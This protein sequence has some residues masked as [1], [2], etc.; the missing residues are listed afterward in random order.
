MGVIPNLQVT[1]PYGRT[2]PNFSLRGISVANEFSASTASPVGV[3][4]DEVYQA[5]RASHGQQLYDLDR[6]EVLRGPQG[7]LYGRNT[8]GGAV[9]FFTR[10]PQLSGS[11]G[12][13]SV[14]YGEYSTKTLTGAFEFTPV[15]GVFGVRFAGTWAD[16]DG[17]QYNPVQER[18]TGTTDVQAARLTLLW[19]PKNNVD[20]TLKLYT[21][22]DNPVAALP[23][24]QGQLQDRQDALGYSRFDPQAFLGGRHLNDDEVASDTGGNYFSSS[25]GMSLTINWDVNDNW[26]LRSITGYDEG[27]YKNSP[28][29]CD[30]S[31]LDL[32]S[33]RYDTESKNF[34]QDVRLVFTGDSVT[35]VA[36]AYYGFDEVDT[37]N[38]PD[39]FG[40]LRDVFLEAGLP[41]SFGN[42]AIATDDSIRVVPGFA[43][44]PALGITDPG[45]CAPV[46][47]G[48]PDGFLD[49]RSLIAL[50]AD[51]AAENTSNGGMGGAISAACRD[52]GAPPFAPILGDQVYTIERPST[53][54]YADGTFSLSED[55]TLSVGLRYTI[56]SVDYVDARTTLLDLAGENI[57]A[58]TIP[59]SYPY[60]P[61]LPDVEQ[62]EST[63]ELTGRIN[64]SYAFSDDVMGYFNLSRGYRSGSFNGLAYQG[65]NQVYY[66]EPEEVVAFETGLKM[67]L[68]DNSMQL[69][70]AGFYYDYINHQVTQ[71]IGA[72]TFTRSLDGILYGGEA[73]LIYQ[74]SANVRIDANL[75]LVGSEYDGNTVDLTDPSSPT[76]ETDGNP[77]PNAPEMTFSFGFDWDIYR[78]DKGI[79]TLHGA[80]SFMDEYF[81]DPYEDYGQSPC[82]QPAEGFSILQA[83]PA[84]TCG[85]PSYWLYNARL[86]YDRDNFSVSLWGKNLG[87]EVYYTYGLNIDVFGLDYLNRGL[88]RTYGVD[89]TLRFGG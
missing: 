65:T 74:I 54:I 30:G 56:D 8:T 82:D 7:T 67:R 49:A 25:D 37:H 3:Y 84:I 47:V 6:V 17:W 16:G 72:T 12:E 46:E 18:E 33:L 35:L 55:L 77:F 38:Q 40:V 71:V 15:D 44:D 64:L 53:A 85:N 43:A 76:R 10:K 1:T 19:L 83:G 41:G 89:F 26:S 34:N 79:V 31:P 27:Q 57:I 24:A 39:F 59:Y 52:A 70:L 48:N 61:D 80:A 5:F 78:G 51:I 63:N 20:I 28:F 75:G 50:L 32:C 62:K 4:V 42:V 88:P 13:F 86:T 2:Q 45:F 36:G 23:Y 60:D 87:D 69:N 21:A 58:S 11:N 14:G 22:E 68:L 66:I 73:E 9:S 81:F 29:D